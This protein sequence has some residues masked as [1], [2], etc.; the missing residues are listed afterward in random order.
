MRIRLNGKDREVVAGTTV[1]RLLDELG[2]VPGMVVVE[3]NHEILGRDSYPT[4]SL[5]EGDRLE[6][7]HF[8][9]GG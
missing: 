9:G 7:V 2:L 5:A 1:S 4:V 3:H 8:V 6:F